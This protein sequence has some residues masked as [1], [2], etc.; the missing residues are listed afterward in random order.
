MS[1]SFADAP[2]FLGASAVFDDGHVPRLPSWVA[3]II[4]LEWIVAL[5]DDDIVRSV[6]SKFSDFDKLNIGKFVPICVSALVLGNPDILAL[7]E[8]PVAI[9]P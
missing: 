7:A 9:V 4:G 5:E 8:I 3:V 6:S 2:C 1:E